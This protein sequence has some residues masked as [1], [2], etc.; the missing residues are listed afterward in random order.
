MHEDLRKDLEEFTCLMYS[1]QSKTKSINELRY[2]LFCAKKG[3]I[4]SFQLPPCQDTLT[5]HI[6]RSNYQAA[7]WRRS[8]LNNAIIPSPIERGWK[9][10]T[11]SDGGSKINIDWMDN[12]PAPKSVLELICCTCRCSRKCKT[13]KCECINNGLKCTDV[14]ACVSRDCDNQAGDAEIE[15]EMDDSDR[16]CDEMFDDDDY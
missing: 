1:P 14:C 12:E 10:E 5:K 15:S 3:A 4:E 8:H 9:L 11:T 6:L 13:P 2:Q 7:I 16:E